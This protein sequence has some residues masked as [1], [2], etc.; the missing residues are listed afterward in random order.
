[1]QLKL[2]GGPSSDPRFL[3]ASAVFSPCK[4]YRYLLT[5]S[6][7]DSK[8]HVTFICLNPS[9]ADEHDLDPTLKRIVGFITRMGH[10]RLVMTNIFAYRATDPRDMKAHPSPIGPENDARILE[11]CRGAKA[12]VAGWGA[13]GTHLGRAAQVRQLL[14]LN[15]V[16]VLCLGKTLSGQPKH[17][18]YLAADTP[19][20]PLT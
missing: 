16:P 14:E 12:V 6:W 10:H 1:M 13:H 9:T 11:A 5:R 3:E 19:L 7:G 17:P 8:G 20:E 2:L 4:Q 18:L 15:G